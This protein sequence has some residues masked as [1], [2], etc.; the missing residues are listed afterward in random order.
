MLNLT[1]SERQALL[2]PLVV[3]CVLGSVVGLASWGFDAEYS[4][5]DRWRM[6]LNAAAAFAAALA[7]ATVPLGILP[8]VIQRLRRRYG[9]TADDECR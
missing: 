8:I 4:H 1:M 2:G 3:G 7:I 9:S 5:I 6:A